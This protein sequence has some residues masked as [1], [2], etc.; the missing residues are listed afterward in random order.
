MIKNQK[1]IFHSIINNFSLDLI[2][3]LLLV[4]LLQFIN[5]ILEAIK[6]NMLLINSDNFNFYDVIKAVYVGNLTALIT[7]KRLGNFIGRSWI[8]SHK[9]DNVTTA[10]I[11]GNIAQ[12]FS[13]V[14][15]AFMAF[16]ALNFHKIN[17]IKLFNSYFLVLSMIYGVILIILYL[18]LFNNKWYAI[19]DQFNFLSLKKSFKYLKKIILINRFQILLISMLRYLV[20]IV[21]YYVLF[22]AFK[23]PIDLVDVAIFVGVVFGL[24]TF[25]PSIAP[26]NLGTREALSIFILGGSIIG[27]QLSS[28]SFI[29]WIINVV[30]SALIGCFFLLY[31]DYK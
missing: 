8:L 21:Q 26:G 25:I 1:E 10:S 12:L 13:T 11:S 5:W 30:I 29:V 2:P 9:V 17:H 31:Q 14:I 16:M 7:P 23:I 18:I 3:F 27:I 24:V 19:F 20:F 6:L 4:L 22:I 28:I 15:M